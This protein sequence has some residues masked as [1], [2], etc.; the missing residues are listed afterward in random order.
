MLSGPKS[1]TSTARRWQPPAVRNQWLSS[2]VLPLPRKPPM[3]VSGRGARAMV[4]TRGSPAS[5][6]PGFEH[7]SGEHGA[8]DA[9]VLQGG[10]IDLERIVLEHAEVGAL[11]AFDRADLVIELER[12]CRAERDRVQR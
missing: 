11:A 7:L 5:A 8:P 1:L 6:L 2:V 9:H 12:P 3:T 10:R 4:E